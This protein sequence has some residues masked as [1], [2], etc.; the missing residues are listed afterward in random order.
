MAA[1][2]CTFNTKR[3]NSSNRKSCLITSKEIN[4]ENIILK[5]NNREI[6]SDLGTSRI[7]FVNCSISKWPSAQCILNYFPMLTGLQIKNSNLNSI[8]KENLRGFINLKEL[9]V[10]DCKI[11]ALPG[12][13]FYYTP[14]LE[15]VSFRSNCI[16]FIDAEIL[17]N[18]RHL[19]VF[20]LLGNSRINAKVDMIKND[21]VNFQRMK[22]MIANDC[23]LRV[24]DLQHLC[25]T[26][27]TTTSAASF[28]AKYEKLLKKL[29]DKDL[30]IDRLKKSVKH[31]MDKS[32]D[33]IIIVETN[34]FAKEF[35]VHKSVIE[36]SPT[37]KRLLE[38]NPDA[39]DLT[40]KD[41]SLPSFQAII[42][43]MYNKKITNLVVNLTELYTACHRLEM[44]EMVKLVS[45]K[46]QNKINKDNAYEYLMLSNKFDDE[47]LRAIAFKEFK[48]LFPNQKLNDDISKQ[49][50]AIKKIMEAKIAMDEALAQLN[51]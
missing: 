10:T 7:C 36:Q 35:E 40:L 22:M 32:R 5:F 30:E 31:W 47:N 46:L 43:Y 28:D 1:I 25:S 39:G 16:K 15:V 51:I 49:P 17:Q 50:D 34:E 26:Q 6:L 9:I 29:K 44:N 45:M 8:V 48:K 42:D 3:I 27:A 37:L 4:E 38:T 21:G 19:K 2:A 20:N 41:I 14:N 13:L 18:C 12:D 11:E 24:A 33:F 23:K